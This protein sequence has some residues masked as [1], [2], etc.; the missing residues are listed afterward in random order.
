MPTRPP[1]VRLI[2]SALGII[3][4]GGVAWTA[5][6]KAPAKAAAPHV[7][8]VTVAKA[9][10]EDVPVSISALGAAQA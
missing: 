3:A 2:L 1:R 5:F 4:V 10:A 9:A 8:A 7:A 6:H